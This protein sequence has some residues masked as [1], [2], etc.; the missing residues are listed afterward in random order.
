MNA[1]MASSSRWVWLICGLFVAALGLAVSQEWY[2]FLLLPFALGLMLITVLRLDL[3][4]LIIAFFTPLSVLF[5]IDVLGAALIL[6]TE[7]L[8]IGVL[9]LF[10]LKFIYE[11][12]RIPDYYKHPLVYVVL[13]MLLW[14]GLTSLTSS[15]PMVSF[16]ATA[17]RLWFL[18]SF[19][20]LGLEL[21]QQRRAF[22]KYLWAYLF[23]MIGVIGYTIVHH[24][25]MGFEKDAAHWVMSPFFKDHTSY[26]A[27][28][29]FLIPPLIAL[30]ANEQRR[31]QRR[32][33][34][35]FALLILLV[36]TVLSYTRAA[37]LSLFAA[38]LVFV[39]VK[40]RI[41]FRFI[42]AVAVIL[43]SLIWVFQDDL[44]MKLEKNNQDS[45][46]NIAE[47]VQSMTNVS[48][49]AS[50][51]ERL[52][53]WGAA[54]RMGAARPLVGW[55][56]GTYQFQYAPF[57]LPS[58]KTVIST[59]NADMGNAHSEYFGPLS[60][61]GL[62]GMFLVIL[63]VAVS[64]ARGLTLAV[65]H[66]DS[67]TRNLAL[68]VTLGLVTYWVHGMLNNFLDT[69]K[70]SVLVWG[71]TAFIVI[72]DFQWRKHQKEQEAHANGTGASTVTQ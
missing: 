19:F 60:E 65:K 27:I 61:Q 22:Q 2:P 21:F 10:V 40:L 11:G 13:V 43:F 8:M 25:I 12:G 52:N 33:M 28:L 23:G 34:V 24:A 51:L 62:P 16:K 42:T 17:S 29:A 32:W 71:F 14:M 45:S 59:N 7:P 26:G 49:D 54:L 53:R 31:T 63:L 30:F 20:F 66:P 41:S 46:G 64:I 9:I 69:D 58:E 67:S 55:G 44:L 18:I 56:P 1:A 39:A 38:L 4:L 5:E 15:M 48:T 36:A 6:P 47:H 68:G 70:A 57:Q 37:W 35:G 50:N 72:L 3:T